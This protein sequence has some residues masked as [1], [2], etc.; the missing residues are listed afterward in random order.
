MIIEVGWSRWNSMKT[1]C[2]VARTQC[3]VCWRVVTFKETIV[4]LISVM[5]GVI[6]KK[7]MTKVVPKNKS[8]SKIKNITWMHSLYHLRVILTM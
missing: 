8:I 7:K 5:G 3:D 4:Y 6:E 2:M 1:C